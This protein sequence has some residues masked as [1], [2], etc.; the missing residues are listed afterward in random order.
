MSKPECCVCLTAYGAANEPRILG[1]GH[2]FCEKCLEQINEVGQR[3]FQ[4]NGRIS[5]QSTNS[6]KCPLCKQKS[7]NHILNYQLRELCT[8]MSKSKAPDPVQKSLNDTLEKIIEDIRIKTK[9]YAE[10]TQEILKLTEELKMLKSEHNPMFDKQYSKIIHEANTEAERLIQEAKLKV[11]KMIQDGKSKS[12]SEARKLYV[13]RIA[14][15]RRKLEEVQK[16]FKKQQDMENMMKFHKRNFI[17]NYDCIIETISE[18]KEMI[19]TL[20]IT[21]GDGN[22]NGKKMSAS[23]KKHLHKIIETIKSW[24]IKIYIDSFKQCK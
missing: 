8:R 12:E 6:Y 23:P 11:E 13:D 18:F 5:I 7:S 9:E 4:S 22:G 16:E 20:N 19:A 14:E 2:T 3:W 10:L 24:D 17:N 15:E 21:V 1:C